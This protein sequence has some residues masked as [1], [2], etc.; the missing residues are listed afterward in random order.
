[1]HGRVAG[2]RQGGN[3]D[4]GTLVQQKCRVRPDRGEVWKRASVIVRK[5]W[6]K[7]E[8]RSS[9]ERRINERHRER[10]NEACFLSGGW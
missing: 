4:R 10:P 9:R 8:G 1:M 5:E 6:R 7:A 3:E 2:E